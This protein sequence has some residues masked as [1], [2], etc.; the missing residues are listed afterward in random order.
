MIAIIHYR[1]GNNKR[2]EFNICIAAG[3][4]KGKTDFFQKFCEGE[5]LPAKSFAVIVG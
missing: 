2:C 1:I 5:E 4:R 3:G